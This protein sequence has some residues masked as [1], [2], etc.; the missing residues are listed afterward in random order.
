MYIRSYIKKSVSIGCCL[1]CLTSYIPITVYAEKPDFNVQV[2]APPHIVFM[3]DSIAS[4]YGLDAYDPDDKSKCAS[5]ANILSQVFDSELPDEAD[6]KFA[7]VAKDGLTSGGLLKKLQDGEMDEYLADA[8]AV[9]VS[10][11]G[12]DLLGPL[13]GLLEKDIGLGETIDRAISLE[14]KLDEHLDQY[15]ENLPEIVDE[16]E[17]RTENEDFTLFI[18]TL[19]NPLEDFSLTPIANMSVDKIGDLNKIIVSVSDNGKRYKVI[20]VAEPFAGKAEE[21]TNIKSY[22]IHPNSD[23]HALIAKTVRD[24]VERETFTY[25][26]NEAAMQYEIELEQQR[27]LEKER[28]QRKRKIIMAGSGAAGIAAVSAGVISIFRKKRR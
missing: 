11:G 16:I 12:N 14:S 7:N 9:V 21:L 10:I 8:D 1:I 20:E 23:G 22:D 6:F 2:N 24:A 28:Q 18:Q 19:Y 4:G 13:E 27:Q 5:Y 26:D 17:S 3:G 25:Y 15:K